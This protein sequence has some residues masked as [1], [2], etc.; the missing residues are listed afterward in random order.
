MTW[1]NGP[2]VRLVWHW[3]WKLWKFWHVG[4]VPVPWFEGR[5]STPRKLFY[6]FHLAKSEISFIFLFWQVFSKSHWS[7]IRPRIF[8]I[9]LDCRP[10]SRKLAALEGKTGWMDEDGK[11]IEIVPRTSGESDHS[12]DAVM[13]NSLENIQIF[14]RF[15]FLLVWY[16]KCG[17]TRQN[18]VNLVSLFHSLLYVTSNKQFKYSALT[19]VE[20]VVFFSCCFLQTRFLSFYLFG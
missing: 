2:N 11:C 13:G 6:N 4:W 1:S 19:I 9:N 16:Y 15:G 18:L 5:F 8:G 3:K 7:W 14:P 10:C 17:K 20:C 12:K